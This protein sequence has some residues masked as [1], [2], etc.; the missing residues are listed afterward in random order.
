M[1][2]HIGS[3]VANCAG[4]LCHV[5]LDSLNISDAEILGSSFFGLFCG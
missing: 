1:F 3:A 2:A 5:H 4:T